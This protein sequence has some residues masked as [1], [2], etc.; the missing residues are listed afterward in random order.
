MSLGSSPKGLICIVRLISW[1]TAAFA[2]TQRF[3]QIASAGID[4]ARAFAYGEDNYLWAMHNK[5]FD[6]VIF[7]DHLF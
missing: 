7:S 6:Y 1:T 4:L 2:V 3:T 5:K